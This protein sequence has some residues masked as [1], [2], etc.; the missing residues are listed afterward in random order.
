[1]RV[2]VPAVLVRD[3]EPSGT[4]PGDQADAT[5]RR[6]VERYMIAINTANKQIADVNLTLQLETLRRRRL[7]VRDL[8]Q[9]L[10]DVHM[11]KL[12]SPSI[13]SV[14]YAQQEMIDLNRTLLA[15]ATLKDTL[16]SWV[17]ARSGEERQE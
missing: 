5:L 2:H 3:F 8:A 4:T 17:V 11:S 15:V 10:E 6:A 16:D 13:P 1:M 9:M 7:T 14:L 12:V